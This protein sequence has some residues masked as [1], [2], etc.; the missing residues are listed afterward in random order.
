MHRR[1]ILRATEKDGER[2]DQFRSR[3]ASYVRTLTV[4][5]TIIQQATLDQIVI[6]I[7]LA[8]KQHN[9]STEHALTFRRRG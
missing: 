8:R 4:R 3:L 6:M 5:V 7:E 1:S 2:N 9:D